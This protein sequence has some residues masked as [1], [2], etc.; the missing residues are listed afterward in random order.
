MEVVYERVKEREVGKLEEEEW[1][2]MK[3]A[4][5]VNTR[6]VCGKRYVGGGIREGSE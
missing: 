1:K 5:A 3:E 4:L 2:P 6:D